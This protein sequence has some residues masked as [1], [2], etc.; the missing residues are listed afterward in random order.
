[1]PLVKVGLSR[2]CLMGAT[3]ALSHTMTGTAF[4][5]VLRDVGSS[6]HSRLSKWRA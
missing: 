6:I 2:G 1:M 3:A 4:G 5:M